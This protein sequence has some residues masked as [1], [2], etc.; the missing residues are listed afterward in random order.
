M[1]LMILEMQLLIFKQFEVYYFTV[2][3]IIPKG[4]TFKTFASLPQKSKSQ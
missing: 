1:S 3:K 2:R 4:K